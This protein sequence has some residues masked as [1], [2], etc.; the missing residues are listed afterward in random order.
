[1]AT[2]APVD[3]TRRTSRLP[4]LPALDGMRGVAVA[5]VV[6][7]HLAPDLVPGGFLGVDVFFVL[8]GFLIASLLVREVEDSGSVSLRQFYLRRLRRLTPALVLVIAA[9]ALYGA[10]AA[11]P[12]ELDRLRAHGLASLAWFANWRFIADGTG[13][14]DVVAGASPLRHMWSLAIEE[15]FY[16][17]FP[18][19]VLGVAA[20]AG[21]ARLRRTLLWVAAGGAVVSAA[22]MAVVWRP[23]EGIERAYYGTDTRAHGLLIGVALGALLAGVPPRSGPVARR[24][25]GLAIAAT[26]AVAAVVLTTTE[27]DGWLYRGGFLGVGLAVAVVIT[28]AGSDGLVS[29]GLSWRPLVLLGLISYGVYLWH[30]PVIVIVDGQ[31][32]GVEGPV[33]VVLQLTLTVALATASYL[34][35]ER[36]IRQG[37]LG[38]RLGRWAVAVAPVGVAAAAVVLVAGTIGPAPPTLG[39]RQPG[40]SGSSPEAVAD[41]PL[42]VVVLGDSVAYTL[43]GGWLGTRTSDFPPWSESMSPFDP[44]VVQ[45]TSLAKPQCSY[46]AGRVLSPAGR[47]RQ[48]LESEAPCGPWRRELA[49]TMLA[50]D[51]E[52]LVVIPAA[53]TADRVV[54]GT[55]VALGSPEWEVFLTDYLDTLDRIAAERGALLALVLPPPRT[56]RFFVDPSGTDVPREAILGDAIRR[57]VTAHPGHAVI[58][59]AGTICP[60]NDCTSPTAGFDPQWRYDGLH[61]TPE[62]ARWFADWLSPSLVR[63]GRP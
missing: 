47:E 31:R 28:A 29:R 7:Y 46:L 4:H 12:G 45:L 60:A 25:G 5:L 9:L 11:S 53:E 44:S 30:W 61:V 58:D 10:V 54:D 22:W 15:Q 27:G 38:R 36:P 57:W 59:L 41:G 8:S 17:V 13:Y 18:V 42:R 55:V 34:L 24:V 35:V 40:S 1:M 16:L 56:G 37:A 14:A 23:G 32:T 3:E 52:A 19:L 62:G 63:L 49:S 51:A 43:T 48:P 26:V 6:A 39:A 33:L 50:T 2:A 20:V 21:R